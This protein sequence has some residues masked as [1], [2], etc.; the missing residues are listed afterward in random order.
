MATNTGAAETTSSSSTKD[1][2]SFNTN[3][4]TVGTPEILILVI[5]IGTHVAWQWKANGG[6]TVTQYGRRFKI[7]NC[8]S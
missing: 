4:F 3:G 2:Q 1:L 7:C 6:T 8:S 5:A